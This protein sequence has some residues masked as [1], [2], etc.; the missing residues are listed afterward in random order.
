MVRMVAYS[1]IL[2]SFANVV[3]ACSRLTI[4]PVVLTPSIPV[5]PEK[6]KAN[7]GS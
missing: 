7:E 3:V 1:L 4:E 2:L 5:T 6:E